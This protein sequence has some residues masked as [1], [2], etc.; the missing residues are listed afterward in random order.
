MAIKTTVPG[1]G[2]SYVIDESFIA[3]TQLT[4]AARKN[5]V[6][7][8][9]A[10]SSGKPQVTTPGGQG[11]LPA[12]VLVS[13]ADVASA[14]LAEV[15]MFGIVEIEA[16]GAFNSGILLTIQGTDGRVEAASSGDYVVGVALEASAEAGQL[17]KVMIN[18]ITPPQLN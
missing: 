13:D 2:S 16:K 12:G 6:L 15:R 14:G 8:W 5:T 4:V 18:T 1:S 10:Q 7:A 11:V 17:V 9:S 3:A